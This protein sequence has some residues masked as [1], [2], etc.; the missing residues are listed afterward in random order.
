M[1]ATDDIDTGGGDAGGSAGDPPVTR[2]PDHRR[3]AA[4]VLR[5]NDV[6]AECGG[7]PVRLDMVVRRGELHHLAVT[8]DQSP[9]SI[10][11]I[12]LGFQ[13][14]DRGQIFFRRWPWRSM[15]TS[16]IYA[17]RFRIARIVD[18]AAWVQNLDIRENILW[19]MRH[20]G[21]AAATADQ[22]LGAALDAMRS[23]EQT[24]AWTAMMLRLERC[25]DDR[26]AFVSPT[27]LR[28]AQWF[29]VLTFRPECVLA[30]RPL[31][32]IP[33]HHHA[34]LLRCV[35]TSLRSGTAWVWMSAEGADGV[36]EG[37]NVIWHDCPFGSPQT[38][39]STR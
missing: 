11:R 33:V 26:P 37:Q 9:E 23:C 6:T 10:S 32:D 16:D 7:R 27:V 30:C 3:A 39:E 25:L 34:P 13:P 28:L 17:S 5:C 36:G 31:R 15:S 20:H 21:I 24:R 35:T 18:T 14:L 1:M 12:L 4:V 8:A 2:R 22:R 19:P 29:R 38:S